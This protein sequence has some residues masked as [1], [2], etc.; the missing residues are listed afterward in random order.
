MMFLLDTCVLSELVKQEPDSK[1]IEW[2]SHHDNETIFIASMT[3]GEIHKGIFRLPNS[4]RKKV[5]Q[6]WIQTIEEEYADK[7]VPFERETAKVW[8][9]MCAALENAGQKM[10]LQDSIIAASALH[11]EMILVTRNI[12]DFQFAPIEVRN[13]WSDHES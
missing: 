2:M 7:T 3:V 10:S 9:N 5:L 6:E 4:Y 8:G 13:P 1:V 12:K 11:H